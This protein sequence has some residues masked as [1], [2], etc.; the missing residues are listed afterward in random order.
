METKRKPLA[1]AEI[2][3]TLKISSWRSCYYS[4]VTRVTKA[5][6]FCGG[7]RY[8]KATG[9]CVGNKYFFACVATEE[10]IKRHAEEKKRKKLIASVQSIDYTKV[11]DECL[12]K[13]LAVVGNYQ[14][15]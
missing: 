9:Y 5:Y 11:P 6:I 4:K 14:T 3:D 7:S 12:E 10:E 8:N 2:G 13:V 1:N 15:C